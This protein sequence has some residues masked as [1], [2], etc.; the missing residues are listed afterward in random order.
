MDSNNKGYIQL[1]HR[2]RWMRP[3]KHGKLKDLFYDAKCEGS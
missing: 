3:Q 1:G 2:Q